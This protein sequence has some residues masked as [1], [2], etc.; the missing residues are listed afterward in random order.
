MQIFTRSK[1]NPILK[2]EPKHDWECFKLYNPGA[3]WDGA[4]YHIFYRAMSRGNDWRSSIGYAVS[5]DGENFE[6]YD[7][8]VLSP[9]NE[10]EKR[11]LEDP[12]ITKFGD[13]YFMVYAAYDGNDVR[14]NIATSKNLKD[15]EKRGPAFSNFEFLKFGGKEVEFNNG[16]IIDDN[17]K[18]VGKEW[19]KSGAIFPEKISNRYWM[20]FGEYNIW[21]AI[22]DN[23]LN[24]DVLPKTLLSSREGNFFDNA[25]VE[26]GSPPIKTKNGW[27]V[28]YQWDR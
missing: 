14:L 1:N 22:S 23:G 16:K 8:P 3:F 19:S 5:F 21:L 26:M 27:L 10:L 17:K 15:W 9:E 28:L 2:P 4:R 7:K 18:R 24:W 11:G 25:F 20:L 13:T 6:R 12:R